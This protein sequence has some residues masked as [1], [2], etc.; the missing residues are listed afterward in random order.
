MD[1]RERALRGTEQLTQICGDVAAIVRTAW[2]RGPAK[3]S[4]YWAGP[5]IVVLLLENGLTDAEKTLAAAGHS[6]QVLMGRVLLQGIVREELRDAVARIVGRP[7]HSV[8]SAWGE[9]PQ[10]AAEVFLLE[11]TEP[12][13]AATPTD[14]ETLLEHAQQVRDRAHDLGEEARALSAQ[15]EQIRRRKRESR[16]E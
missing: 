5:N 10:I 16:G 6:E 2:G 12:M 7:V 4:A 1:A 9:D 14:A 15:H 3:T 8:L 13:P 11:A